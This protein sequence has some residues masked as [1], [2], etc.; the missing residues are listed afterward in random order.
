MAKEE[1]R[2]LESSHRDTPSKKHRF[3]IIIDRA[4]M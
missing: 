2:K 4:L 1:E 3:E